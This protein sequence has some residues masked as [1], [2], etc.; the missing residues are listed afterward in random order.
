M[1]YRREDEQAAANPFIA[2][3]LAASGGDVDVWPENW[4]V[5]ELFARLGTQWN[6]GMS[7][8]TGLRYEAIYPLLDRLLPADDDWQQAFSD[9]Q[10]MERAALDA[11]R[12]KD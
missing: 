2:A 5:V 8:P 9:L 12:E 6:I 4:P 11:L 3:V 7:G 1:L 10:A